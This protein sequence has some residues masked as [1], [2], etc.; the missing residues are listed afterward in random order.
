M[1]IWNFEEE[2]EDLRVI[3]FDIEVVQRV[4]IICCMLHNIMLSEMETRDDIGAV[5]SGQPT[6]ADAIWIGSVEECNAG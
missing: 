6:S 4:F 1:Y 5:V 3:W 2:M